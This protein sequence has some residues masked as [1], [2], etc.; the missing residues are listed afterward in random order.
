MGLRAYSM[1]NLMAGR[2]VRSEAFWPDPSEEKEK[3]RSVGRDEK[4][5]SCV[6]PAARWLV[7]GDGRRARSQSAWFE[8]TDDAR[9]EPKRG[10]RRGARLVS[11]WMFDAGAE[12]GFDV[13]IY[14]DVGV[15]I[16]TSIWSVCCRQPQLLT[17]VATAGAFEMSLSVINACR[18]ITCTE[19]D[20]RDRYRIWSL[21]VPNT[22]L[23]TY[24]PTYQSS[25]S[26]SPTSPVSG[27]TSWSTDSLPVQPVPI[28]FPRLP[29]Q[30]R[31][32]HRY[33]YAACWFY[34][35]TGDPNGLRPNADC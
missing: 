10:T 15:S 24:L 26:A 17:K 30:A 8:A 31:P 1:L 20:E 32:V 21:Q 5:L 25:S 7:G 27:F 12:S 4:R 6:G 9:N 29:S 13:G 19:L 34:N 28:G 35:K 33:F 11:I 23:G 18:A 16:P 14:V 22:Y 3:G 2:R